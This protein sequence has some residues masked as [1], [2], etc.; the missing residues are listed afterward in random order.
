M[1]LFLFQ[2]YSVNYY[3]EMKTG[4]IHEIF[5]DQARFDRCEIDKLYDIIHDNIVLF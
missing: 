5:E 2:N 1:E 4:I 3:F